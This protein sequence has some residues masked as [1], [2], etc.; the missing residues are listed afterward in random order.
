MRREC[1]PPCSCRSPRQ[2]SVP[3]GSSFRVPGVAGRGSRRRP[4]AVPRG[5][6]PGRG[7]TPEPGGRGG[8]WE[9][10]KGFCSPA[11]RARP[12]RALG[13]PW[14]GEGAGGGRSPGRWSRFKVWTLLPPSSIPPAPP[15]RDTGI[16]PGGAPGSA[17]GGWGPARGTAAEGLPSS[18]SV[19]GNTR[20]GIPGL[21]CTSAAG[22]G[23]I[24]LLPH[25]RT[26][27]GPFRTPAGAKFELLPLKCM[28]IYVSMPLN[29]FF[30]SVCLR[31]STCI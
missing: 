29:I 22:A 15:C 20:L 26:K 18:R 14:G 12:D 5:S 21:A 3:A 17:A 19:M 2:V 1:P 11:L 31:G 30:S 6:G 23:R 27:L 28:W 10:V 4:N 24:S 7:C 8:R 9:A 13:Q 25:P 16:G